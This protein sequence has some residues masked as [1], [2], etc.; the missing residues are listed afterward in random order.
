M[1][2]VGKIVGI[3]LLDHFIIGE[4]RYISLREQGIL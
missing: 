1:S 2:E 4:E 3:E